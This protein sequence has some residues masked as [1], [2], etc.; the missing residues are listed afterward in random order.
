[1]SAMTD[2]TKDAL[3]QAAEALKEA[4]ARADLEKRAC[5]AQ[6]QAELP[7]R[8]AET[9]KRIATDQPEV[10]KALGKEGVA[11]MRDA[12]QSASE[13]LGRQFVAAVDEIDWPLGSGNTK[14]GNY[15]V[16]SALFDRFHNKTGALSKVLKDNGYTLGVSDAFLPQ[17]LYVESKFTSV[18]AALTALGIASANFKKAKKNDDDAVVDDLWG[19]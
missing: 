17:S 15:K 14:V 6:I 19:D 7:A 5:L 9:A 13:E 11:N 3:N 10:T 2:E 8:A 18:A 4:R 12:L 16:H 1:M